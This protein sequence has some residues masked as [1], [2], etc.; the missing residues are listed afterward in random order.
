MPDR[1]HATDE[2]ALDDQRPLDRNAGVIGILFALLAMLGAWATFA[3]LDEVTNGTGRI[4][5]SSREQ[6]IQSLEGGILSRLYVAEG[7]IVEANQVLAQL[8]ATRST[9]NVDESAAKYRAAVAAI[10]RLE[11]EVNGGP[12][13]FPPD[14]S[15]AS[16]LIQA[17]TRLYHERRSR[18]AD[19][20]AGARATLA[21][22][23]EELQI[24]SS[25]LRAGA[26]SSVEVIRL[27]RQQ[28]EQETKIADTEA[29]YRVQARE[30]LAKA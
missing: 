25:L 27:K 11:A 10:A 23:R 21:L 16:D 13:Q 28:A 24:T 19:S 14:I 26:A 12:L 8:D 18:L 1:R 5:P 3:R 9:S 2:L 29:N 30:E 17:E 4:V 20:L 6:V 15:H 22:V 7:D